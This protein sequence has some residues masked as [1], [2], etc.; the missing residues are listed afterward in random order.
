MHLFPR[1]QNRNF[2]MTLNDKQN[3]TTNV[4]VPWNKI[5]AL[6]PPSSPGQ[7][8]GHEFSADYYSSSIGIL[9][10]KKGTD[11]YFP[12]IL[13]CVIFTAYIQR[14]Y[15][16]GLYVMCLSVFLHSDKL[17]MDFDEIWYSRSL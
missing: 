12:Q 15:V 4:S 10:H 2:F 8:N 9:V 14:M 3:K 11:L 5:V 13:V 7:R 1:I 17:L 6:L 16:V